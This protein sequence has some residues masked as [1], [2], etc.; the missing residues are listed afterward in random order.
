MIHPKLLQTMIKY[1][2]RPYSI[3]AA[4][5]ISEKNGPL[6]K[7]IEEYLKKYPMGEES[8]WE[9]M[10]LNI[11]RVMDGHPTSLMSCELSKE[12]TIDKASNMEMAE[13]LWDAYPGTFPLSDGGMFIARK[14]PDKH[15]VLSTYLQR[16]NHDKEKHEYV[17]Q[18]LKVYVKL[19]LER[20]INGHRIYDWISNEM[21]D[22]IP[23]LEAGSRGEF[24]TDI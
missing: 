8:L 21:W 5:L 4:Y 16:I 20:K 22:I 3:V 11:I 19:V 18:Q 15:E 2:Y 12:F 23:D 17:L 14:G 1:K 9:L 6:R 10:S 13:E 24:K 7:D